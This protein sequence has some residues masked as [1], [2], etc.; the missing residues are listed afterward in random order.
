VRSV[1]FYGGE[2]DDA[3]LLGFGFSSKMECF[4]ETLAST[5][6]PTRRQNAEEQH[7]NLRENWFTDSARWE[8]ICW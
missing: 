2:D 4:S 1:G 5:D 8:F 7:H 6:E 3:L